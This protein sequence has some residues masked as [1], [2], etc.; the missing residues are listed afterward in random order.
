MPYGSLPCSSQ[1]QLEADGGPTGCGA[2]GFEPDPAT[3]FLDDRLAHKQAKAEARQ[4]PSLCGCAAEERVEDMGALRFRHPN[5][6]IAD[7][8]TSN[9]TNTCEAH[10]DR[11][12]IRT[13]PHGIVDQIT[14]D[15]LHAGRIPLPAQRLIIGF[16]EQLVALK[17]RP[18]MFYRMAYE[19]YEIDGPR[20]DL[21]GVSLDARGVEQL[22]DH[23]R[24]A[25]RL[26][27]YSLES[28][29]AIPRK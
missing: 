4:I 19:C 10:V 5:T 23:V 7:T 15:L 14:N 24:H 13:V 2:R 26:L 27:F 16:Q 11:S 6:F 21:K 28:M 17:T 1:G 12:T 25:R 22:G 8:H 20:M 9:I 18:S 29:H 3:R